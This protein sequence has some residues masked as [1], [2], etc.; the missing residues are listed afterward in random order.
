MTQLTKKFIDQHHNQ[1]W[2]CHKFPITNPKG[3]VTG[4]FAFHLFS[5]HGIPKEYLEEMVTGKLGKM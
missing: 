4:Q 1:C 2:Q 3:E 5:V